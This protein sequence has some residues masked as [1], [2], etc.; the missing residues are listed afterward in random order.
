[1]AESKNTKKKKKNWLSHVLGGGFLTEDFV[2]RQSKLLVLIVF[3]IIIFISNRYSCMK[4]LTEIENLKTELQ[5]VKYENLIISTELTSNSRQSQIE[6]M[7]ATKGVGLR[8][9]NASV[10][11]IQK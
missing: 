10:Y 11:K 1:M 5:D 7:L 6:E 9:S 4:K 8:S 3:L 2:I